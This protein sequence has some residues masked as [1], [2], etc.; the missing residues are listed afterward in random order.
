MNS[1]T[2][3]KIIALLALLTVTVIAIGVR[4]SYQQRAGDQVLGKDFQGGHPLPERNE[5]A[6]SP[7]SKPTPAP[8][9]KPIDWRSVESVDYRKYIANMKAIGIPWVTIKDIIL[10]DVNHLY[11]EKAAALGPAP[12]LNYWEAG[13]SGTN[14][15]EAIRRGKLDELEADRRACLKELIGEESVEDTSQR[16]AWHEPSGPQL[17]FLSPEKR[18]VVDALSQYDLRRD[19][20]LQ[21]P[22]GLLVKED[23]AEMKTLAAEKRSLLTS[24]LTPAELQHYDLVTHSNAAAMR[25]DLQGFKP[26]ESEFQSVFAILRKVDDA[27]EEAKLQAQADPSAPAIGLQLAAMSDEAEKQIQA[28]LGAA[29][30]TDYQRTRDPEFLLLQRV[31]EGT[32]LPDNAILQAYQAKKTADEQRAQVEVQLKQQLSQFASPPASVETWFNGRMLSIQQQEEAA[33]RSALGPDAFANYAK[34]TSVA[35]RPPPSN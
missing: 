4:W 3:S 8:S 22:G 27:S 29:R 31:S 25:R 17:D 9:S 15:Q 33:L 35:N 6:N 7:L 21:R 12:K 20:I 34:Q 23:F 32:G 30:Y 26:T 14:S 10:A 18:Q 13:Q 1:T 2:R 24:L 11:A 19:A 28:A 5:S 16:L